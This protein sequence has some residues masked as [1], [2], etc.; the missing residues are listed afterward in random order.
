[1]AT[2]RIKEIDTGVHIELWNKIIFVKDTSMK[3]ILKNGGE[4]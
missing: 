1:M 4:G 3:T 2:H